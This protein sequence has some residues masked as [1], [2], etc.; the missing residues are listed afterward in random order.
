MSKDQLDPAVWR[1]DALREKFARVTM[2][3]SEIGRAP[4]IDVTDDPQ[5][6][7]ALINP[8]FVRERDLRWSLIETRAQAIETGVRRSAVLHNMFRSPFV[9]GKARERL[10]RE[11][12]MHGRILCLLLADNALELQEWKNTDKKSEA[13]RLED[14]SENARVRLLGIN[15]NFSANPSPT[16]NTLE[17][18]IIL[19]EYESETISLINKID[20]VS[21]VSLDVV[22]ARLAQR[23]TLYAAVPEEGAHAG[24]LQKAFREGAFLRAKHMQSSEVY[25]SACHEMRETLDMLHG[26]YDGLI[27]DGARANLRENCNFGQLLAGLKGMDPV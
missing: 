10:Y 25:V 20:D 23:D 9:H 27:L 7:Y 15:N 11:K 1:R 3:E 4:G 19:E 5:D 21:N 16:M 13:L 8:L 18:T 2:W 6:L 17:A 12:E 24:R 22:M 26:V 14:Q